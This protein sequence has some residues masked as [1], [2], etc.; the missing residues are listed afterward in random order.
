MLCFAASDSCSRNIWN[1][2]RPTVIIAMALYT[3]QRSY[4]WREL[5][6]VSFLSRQFFCDKHMFVATKRV[7]CRDKSMLVATKVLSRQFFEIIFVMTKVLRQTRVCRDK[8]GTSGSS[9]QC[10]V[11]AFAVNRNDDR[12]AI[13]CT[14]IGPNRAAGNHFVLSSFNN[15][16]SH[17]TVIARPP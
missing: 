16:S 15:D 3:M 4:Q 11:S 9:R 8:N 6:Q 12:V 1:C 13:W 17:I 14:D 7:F 5:P 2:E 10:Y